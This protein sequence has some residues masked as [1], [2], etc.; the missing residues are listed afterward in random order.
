MRTL[1]WDRT[2]P[3]KVSFFVSKRNLKLF[4]SLGYNSY[5]VFIKYCVISIF[6][7]IFRTVAFNCF[8]LMSVY[9][10]VVY[11]WFRKK[12]DCFQEDFPAELAVAV[13]LSW[14]YRHTETTTVEVITYIWMITH[15]IRV[16]NTWKIHWGNNIWK[17]NLSVRGNTYKSIEDITHE[18]L[19]IEVM[20]CQII[21]NFFYSIIEI[22]NFEFCLKLYLLWNFTFIYRKSVRRKDQSC[23]RT[24]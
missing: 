3:D 13:L 7:L 18:R 6:F 20:L 23:D 4:P 1:P 11:H 15:S 21:W 19:S 22:P 10:T 9:I 17:V 16:M 5:R 2:D 8:P 14:V 24:R 12:S